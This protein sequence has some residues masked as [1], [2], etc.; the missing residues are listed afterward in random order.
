MC[1]LVPTN[2]SYNFG[3]DHGGEHI[4]ILCKLGRDTCGS[5]FGGL[6]YVHNLKCS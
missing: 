5:F 4:M 3:E 1:A 6:F 2:S